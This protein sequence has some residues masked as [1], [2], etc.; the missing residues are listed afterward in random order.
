MQTRSRSIAKTALVEIAK[1]LK[2]KK[3]SSNRIRKTVKRTITTV[4]APPA[5]EG[6]P[7]EVLIFPLAILIYKGENQT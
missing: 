2:V 5:E 7:L 1:V 4:A 6:H 3:E